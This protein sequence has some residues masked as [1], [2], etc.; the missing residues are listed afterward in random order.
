MIRVL[1]ADGSE[2]IRANLQRRLAAEE[3]I[4][5]CGT[6]MDG[7]HALQEALHLVP[8]IVIL[9]A[10]LSGLDGVQ[11]TEML[12]EYAPQAGVILMSM[13]SGSELFRRAMLAGAREVLQK[14]FTGDDMVAAIHRV[15]SFQ[16]RKRAAQSAQAPAG[17]TQPA[18]DGA[19]RR[20]GRMITIVS[21][22]GGVGKS[23]IATNLALILNRPKPGSVVLV[24]LSLQFGDIAALLAMTPDGTIAEFAASEASIGDRHV[25]Q[26]ALSLGPQGL[27]VLAAPPS[28]E[29]A[30]YVT[31]AHLRALLAELRTSFE[32]VVTDT[33]AQLSE[34]TLE[35]LENSDHI[36]LVTDF[37]VT[38]VKNTRLI[39][40]V[41]GVLQVDPE[42]I[43]VVANHRDA[44]LA[45]GMDRARI[46][47]FLRHSVAAEIPHD[48]AAI[49][50]SVSLG[51]PVVMSGH[52][53]PATAAFERL[54][55]AVM[56]NA[57]PADAAEHEPGKKRGRRR[58]GFASRA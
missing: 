23:I 17:G 2:R 14:P 39:M 35:A 6:A 27:T 52:S 34:I 54:A 19:R 56:G 21:G 50:A 15:H 30:D 32:L 38:S 55:A 20:D 16:A 5:V 4:T 28:P 8:D 48:A 9:D 51:V 25:I 40:S 57:G 18:T 7:E 53:T 26:Q 58:L 36:L 3:D 22:K 41:I 12:A 42:R 31:T 45:G 1:V 43:L 44:P 24:D 47:D 29:L 46:E 37:S 13:E 11:A 33:T 10:G 49:G